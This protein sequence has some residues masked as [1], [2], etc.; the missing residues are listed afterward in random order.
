MGQAAQRAKSDPSFGRIPKDIKEQKRGLVVSA[1]LTIKGSSFEIGS[2]NLDPQE[3]R[4]SLLFW[5]ELLQPESNLIY[6][7]PG[8]SEQF[9]LDTGILRKQATYIEGSGYFS[10]SLAQVHIETF[11]QLDKESPGKWSLA[12]GPRSFNWDNLDGGDRS[13]FYL[14]LIRA[15]PVPNVDVPLQEILEFKARRHPELLAL[16]S[17]VDSFAFFISK[18]DDVGAALQ[19][20][21]EFVE[22]ACRDLLSVGMEWK[23]PVRIADLKCSFEIN[24]GTVFA[25][26]VAGYSAGTLLAMP[27][28]SAAIA[29][30]ASAIKITGDLKRQ[31]VMPRSTPYQYV[32]N[33][34][35]EIF[36]K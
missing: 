11:K 13:G 26:M 9:L 10:Q 20:K 15:I 16:R 27:T 35:D 29:G 25:A 4:Y 14:E 28:L 2:P 36:R 31:P 23:F 30:A 32:Y 7:E 6:I 17:E 22:S 3:L 1:P 8:E 18:S 12:T 19:K 24:P 33:F 5:D 34:H 21:K